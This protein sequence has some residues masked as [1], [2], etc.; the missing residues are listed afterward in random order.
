MET[1]LRDTIAADF[2]NLEQPYEA[3]RTRFVR[4]SPVDPPDGRVT[5]IKLDEDYAVVFGAITYSS[6]PGR[7]AGREWRS[8]LEFT[9][10]PEAEAAELEK[11][12]MI[13]R[14][15]LGPGSTAD[16]PFQP[17]FQ[18]VGTKAEADAITASD[19]ARC[20]K[21]AGIGNV[22]RFGSVRR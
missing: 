7:G 16:C 8:S 2:S 14:G 6:I 20:Q 21:A 9:E 4:I 13:T 22:A 10:V 19:K 11:V 12:G 3:P 1:D 17:R 15:M 18:I 5:E